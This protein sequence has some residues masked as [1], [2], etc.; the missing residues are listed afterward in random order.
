RGSAPDSCPAMATWQ[1]RGKGV[2]NQHEGP[3]P[4]GA[5]TGAPGGAGPTRNGPPLLG[6]LFLLLAVVGVLL[7]EALDPAGGV[8]E[9]HL[10]G[11]ERVAGRADLDRD[12][13]LGAAGGELVAAA[14]GHCRLDVLRVDALFHGTTPGR[15]FETLLYGRPRPGD[16]AEG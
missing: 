2:G 13:L 10:A 8:H 6:L 5:R 11:E 4:P 1:A 16:K 7:L 3:A 9:L 14:A 12:R 15:V